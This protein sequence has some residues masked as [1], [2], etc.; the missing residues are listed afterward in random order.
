MY[1][2]SPSSS[3]RS[4]RS[5]HNYT[6][7]TVWT[8]STPPTFSSTTYGITP[9]MGFAPASP[10][11]SPAWLEAYR[12][13]SFGFGSSG[14]AMGYGANIPDPVSQRV[15]NGNAYSPPS[16]SSAAS[17]TS[18]VSTDSHHVHEKRDFPVK[19]TPF[20]SEEIN[21]TS[22][23]DA[24]ATTSTTATTVTETTPLH[25]DPPAPEHVKSPPSLRN[26]TLVK[27]ITPATTD[28]T[29]TDLEVE[30][31]SPSVLC[32]PTRKRLSW[33]DNS[34]R[35]LEECMAFM[36][37]DEPWRCS[38]TSSGF[39]RSPIMSAFLWHCTSVC[40]CKIIV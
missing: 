11:I 8:E 30:T 22:S 40:M 16:F 10:T 18:G 33:A 37:D 20:S 7:H 5:I 28:G 6:A 26:M 2:A 17:S 4:P 14:S 23:T 25:T 38:K 1:L 21:I 29:S 36:R 13:L 35:M 32:S 34:G 24:T 39:R 31:P 3:P 15:Q 19:M 9:K 12:Q 27:E